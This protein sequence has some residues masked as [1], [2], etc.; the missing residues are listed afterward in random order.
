ME[1]I[2]RKAGYII[3]M[4]GVLYHGNYL[5]PGASEFVEWLNRENK[6][7]LFLTNSSERSPRELQLKLARMGIEVEE[8]HFYTSALATASFLAKQCPGGSAYIIGEPGLVKALYDVGFSMNDVNPDYVVVGETRS[9][10]Y[11]K[12]ELAVRLVR[13]GAKLIGT[14]PDLT[15]PS[16]QGIIPATKA[17]I[18]PIELATG[19]KAYYIGKPNPLMMRHGLKLLGTSTEDTVIIGDRMDTDIVAGIEADIDTVLVLSGVTSRE[20]L[21]QFPYQPHYILNG[22]GELVP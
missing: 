12:I 6:K 4:D 1:H 18:A 15:G 21:Q 16:E 3:D 10:N 22:V 11:E 19:K 8:S 2:R 14:N 17:L 7:Y 13:Q 5:L 9:Y 20:T